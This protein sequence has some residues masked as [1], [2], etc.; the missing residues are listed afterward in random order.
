MFDRSTK[1]QMIHSPVDLKV[2]WNSSPIVCCEDETELEAN[3][4][5]K[6]KILKVDCTNPKHIVVPLTEMLRVENGNY[7]TEHPVSCNFHGLVVNAPA[8]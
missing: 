8:R 6:R 5:T 1:A 3:C 7:A 2:R 4:G